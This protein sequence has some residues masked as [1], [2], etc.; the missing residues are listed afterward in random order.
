MKGKFLL[1]GSILVSFQVFSQVGINTPNPQASLDVVGKP[2]ST[3]VFDG[4][5]A[6]RITGAQ[7]RAK[8]YTKNQQG[9]LVYITAADTAPSGQTTEVTSTGYFYFDSDLNRWQKLNSGAVTM[10]DPTTDAFIDDPANTMVKL[11]AASTG[12]ARSSN[13]DFVIKDNGRVGIGT[14]LPDTAL[15]IKENG[16]TNSNQ[17][18]VQATNSSP[19]ITL[20]RTGS[21]NLS[22]GA[23]LGKLTFNGKIAG[24][25]FSLAGIKANYWG[26]GTT[27]SSSLTFSTS[28]RPAVVI[29]ESGNMGIGRSDTNYAMSP[30]QKLDVDGNVRFRDVPSSTLNSTDMLMALD[31]N[32]VA[33][34][35]DITAPTSVLVATRTGPSAKSGD[36]SSAIMW[37]ENTHQSNNTYLTRIDN[38][39]FQANKTG[40]YTI[41]ITAH[42][43]Q[44][45]EGTVEESHYRGVSVGVRTTTDKLTQHYGSNYLGDG[46]T[47]ITAVFVLNAGEQFH[48]Y[49]QCNKGGT[50]RQMEATMSVVY[51]PF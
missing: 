23:E 36:G 14:D 40:L 20:E 51:T 32:G 8:T 11:G 24:A 35:V 22:S 30:T 13:T 3:N 18:K 7:L 45:P 6:P 37:F 26:T 21:N 39:T 43:D 9:A 28:D 48:A 5:I 19:L 49:S 2:A 25:N 1:L 44:V 42:F 17:L 38:G 29:N 34:K 16:N 10:G 50:Y 47:N 31:N 41:N 4:I 46:Y 33:K 27:N 15:H 12:T